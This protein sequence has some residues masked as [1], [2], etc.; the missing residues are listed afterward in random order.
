MPFRLVLGCGSVA[1]RL[2]VADGEPTRVVTTDEHRVETLRS[3]GVTATRGDPTDPEVL[4][5]VPERP[6]TVVVGSH[7]PDRNLTVARL[8]R[9]QFP[10][11]RL[12]AVAGRGATDADVAALREVADD[13][14]D[15]R[16]AISTFLMDRVGDDGLRTRRLKRV[17]RNVPGPL[18][19]VAHDNPDPDAIAS[20]VALQHVAERAGTPAEACYFGDISHQENRALVNLLEFELTDLDADAD[21]SRFGAVALVDHSRPG[22][23][24][25]LPE[26][27]EIDIVI[28]HHPP[29]A[30]VEARFVDLRSD[31]GST[32]TLLTDY[33][34]RLGIEPSPALATAL[35]FGIHV[36]TREFSRE[37]ALE[38]FEAA[39]YLV[40]YA[41]TALLERIES[42]SA[43]V[44]TF[45]I[46]GRAIVER[47]V[48]GDVLTTYVGEVTDR[49]ALAQAADRLLGLE[50]IATT[51]VFGCL[52]DTIYVSARARGT[53]VDLGEALR[54]AFGQIGS[55]GGHADMA[56]A[57]IPVGGLVGEEDD[58]DE[59][60]RGVLTDRFFETLGVDENTAAA[61]V[62]AAGDYLGAGLADR[63]RDEPGDA[64]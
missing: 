42:P 52:D 36:D 20:A 19:V 26:D 14:H 29:R 46:I 47:E 61:A 51:L 3:D 22:V 55:A 12:F 35:L 7:D 63:R 60:I 58:R 39:A 15:P 50:G 9:E 41:D 18:A 25:Q 38:D 32:S 48:R 28:D 54:D 24:D 62:Y 34:R 2:A 33:L 17:L 59:V 11:A 53:G 43:S 45:E 13:V 40:G 10:D 44:E 57:Q 27:T 8:A 6:D 21:L 1:R 31:V 49:D 37:V 56:G 16:A 64:A 4:A 5:A 30:P 23:N